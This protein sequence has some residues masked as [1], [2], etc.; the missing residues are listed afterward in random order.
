M[1]EGYNK[2]HLDHLWGY[3]FYNYARV[4]EQ[5]GKLNEI[6]IKL[7]SLY[8]LSSNSKNEASQAVLLNQILR[9]FILTNNYT[10]A[11]DFLQ[12]TLFP[13][14]KQNNEFIKY[15]YYTS[16]IKATQGEYQEAFARVNQS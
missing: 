10:S 4:G 12:N 7:F 16:K 11:R 8:K 1:I 2:W 3:I 5:L 14:S 6:R 15:L 9:N 13:E